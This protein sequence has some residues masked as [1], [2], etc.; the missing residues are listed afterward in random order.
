MGFIGLL[1]RSCEEEFGIIYWLGEIMMMQDWIFYNDVR[2]NMVYLLL[3]IKLGLWVIVIKEMCVCL[4]SDG[5]KRW[6]KIM[7]KVF[8]VKILW[9]LKMG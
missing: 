6:I 7:K 3:K 1:I 8:E 5:W 2:Y 9:Q 4:V